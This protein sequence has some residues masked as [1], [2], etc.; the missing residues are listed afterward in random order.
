M[1][2]ANY[3]KQQK[4]LLL[5][6][7]LIIPLLLLA[8]FS[9]YPAIK[10][11]HLSFMQWNGYDPEM[12]FTGLDNYIDVFTDDMVLMTLLNSL[13]Y[14][15]ALLIQTGLAL[16][17][18][19]ILDG[20]LRAKNFF[21]TINFMPYILNGVA[22]AFM[23]TYLYNFS[24][25]PI[26]YIIRSFRWGEGFKF[27]ADNYSI[28]FSLAFISLWR[29]TGFSMVIFLSALQS[30]PPELYESASLDG[31]NFF[32]H[33][34]YITIPNIKRMIWLML[35]LGFNGCLQVFFEPMVITR[36]GPGG[37]SDTWVTKTISIA[38]NF[39]NFGKA[40][41]MGVVLLL[42][43]F[44]VIGIQ[45]LFTRMGDRNGS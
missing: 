24:D 9:F 1:T 38:F 22:V 18:A 6:G 17:L 19:I 3:F 12:S 15:V 2:I 5:V 14:F 27:L 8:V 40:S 7:F 4:V 23:F 36:G 30:I 21:R 16:Y 33:I 10:L 44:A 13:A 20:Q 25:S 45:W 28:N 37:L 39:H 29:F 32:Q 43:V 41:A 26:N 35:F 42:I 34:R 11:I 31:A